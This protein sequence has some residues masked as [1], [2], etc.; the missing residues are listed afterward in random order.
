MTLTLYT[1][2]AQPEN[3]QNVTANMLI[4][5]FL[6]L[7]LNLDLLL[8]LALEVDQTSHIECIFVISVSL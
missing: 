8:V 3:C 4:A 2:Q 5:C 6:V 7:T 1:T